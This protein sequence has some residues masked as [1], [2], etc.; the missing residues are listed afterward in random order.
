MKLIKLLPIIP[1]VLV[2]LYSQNQSFNETQKKPFFLNQNQK[3]LLKKIE[4]LRKNDSSKIVGVHKCGH[5][6]DREFQIWQK[7]RHYTTF[8]KLA[9]YKKAKK[10]KKNLKLKGSL[11]K[12]FC[13]DC[14]FTQKKIKQKTKVISGVSCESCHNSGKDW[15]NIHNEYAPYTKE[16]EP[17]KHKKKR[18]TSAIE[19]GLRSPMDIYS[20]AQSCYQ[21]HSVPNEQL[22]NKG[23]HK[24]GSNF[25][26]VRWSQGKIRHNFMRGRHG[27][28][29][30][31]SQKRKRLMLITGILLELEYAFRGLAKS[32]VPGKYRAGMKKRATTS[33][34]KLQHIDKKGHIQEVK[35]AIFLVKSMQKS[36]RTIQGMLV[37]SNLLALKNKEFNQKHDGQKLNFLDRYL[38]KK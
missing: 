17:F 4:F 35:D 11:K 38:P 36:L 5:C 1:V 23:G 12:N 29:E 3:K 28:N 26:L 19:K 7:T 8:S 6:H 34:Q 10:I 33:Y 2:I 16:T 27:I 14:H 15:I 21:C 25:E 30:A 22:V 37:L 20:L 32:K 13:Q 31:S 24:A 9:K 18:I